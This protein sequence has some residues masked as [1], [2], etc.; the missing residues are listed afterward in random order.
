M[1][2]K[3]NGAVWRYGL[4]VWRVEASVTSV[5]Y[6]INQLNTIYFVEFIQVVLCI[7]WFVEI[8]GCTGTQGPI[9]S[10]LHR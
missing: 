9:W 4:I 10:V 6:F 5:F 7:W 2:E 3:W 1:Y 8:E